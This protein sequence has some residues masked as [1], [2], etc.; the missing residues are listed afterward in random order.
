[1]NMPSLPHG[2]SHPS[3]LTRSLLA[4]KSEFFW[5]GTFSLVA[6]LLTLSPTLYMLQV[7]DR[8]MLSQSELTLIALTMITTVFVA[9]MAFAEWVRSR[10]LVR[11][12]VR[13]DEQL[14]SRIFLANF[15]A[16]LAQTRGDTANTFASLTRLRQFLTGNGIIAFFDLPWTPIYIAV[17]FVMHPLLGWFAIVFSVFLGALAFVTSQLTSVRV[18]QATRAESETSTYLSGKLRNAEVVEA[19]GMLGNLKRRWLMLYGS[20]AKAHWQAQERAGIAAAVSKFIQYSQQSLILALGAWLAIRGEISAG[21]MIASNVLMGNA[22]RPIGILV[23]T[24]KEFVQARQSYADIGKL[25]DQYPERADGHAPGKVIGQITVR[26][27]SAR[28]AQR[29]QPILDQIDL[30]FEAGEVIGIVGPSGAGKSTLA[31]CLIGIWPET[32][33]QV[34][35]D[36]VDIRQWSR[37]PLGSRIGYLPQDIELFEGTVAENICRFDAMDSDAII[38]A[39]KRADIHEMIL[40][41]PM[42]YDTPVGQA[43]KLLSGGQRQRLALARAIFGWPELIVLDEPN[44]NLDETGEAALAAVIRQ[45]KS[46]GK[47]VFMVLHQRNLLALADRVVVLAQGRVSQFGRLD[48]NSTAGQAPGVRASY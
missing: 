36:G 11:A 37:E 6:N 17:L 5:V 20:H 18:E 12:G 4:F 30:R 35:L 33:G 25:L 22:L 29:E 21:A 26:Q 43:G 42:G 41:L 45:L 7:F 38:E 48:I 39:A 40:R 28:A 10:L 27:F 24:W 46:D 9:V 47:T 19:M 34:L 13:F 16:N 32:S 1:M 23:S 3:S 31:R 44:A 15:Q 14:N 2:L 8:V